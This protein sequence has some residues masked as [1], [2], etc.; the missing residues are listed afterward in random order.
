[1]KP[2]EAKRRQV[3]AI[4]S[5]LL[6]ASLFMGLA[7]NQNVSADG[8]EQKIIQNVKT[9][10]FGSDGKI[11]WTGKIEAFSSSSFLGATF[12]EAPVTSIPVKIVISSDAQLPLVGESKT[13]N[14]CATAEYVSEPSKSGVP[15]NRLAIT[16]LT[17]G[18]CNVLVTNPGN[19]T[20][21][22]ISKEI[23]I[24]FAKAKQYVNFTYNGANFIADTKSIMTEGGAQISVVG[25]YPEPDM[26]SGHLKVKDSLVSLTK[27][28]CSVALY[29]ELAAFGTVGYKVFAHKPGNCTLHY[30]SKATSQYLAVDEI[31]KFK[32]VTMKNHMNVF[33][34]NPRLWCDRIT[35]S[36]FELLDIPYKTSSG[37]SN[38]CPNG[39]LTEKTL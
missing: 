30:K 15:N 32:F 4:F 31:V 29:K 10:A 38:S 5:I 39:Y 8:I 17:E 27:P 2:S 18:L 19:E 26:T 37:K 22:P 20:V 33:T 12:Y 23:S 9:L 6:L 1:M 34:K 21:M 25:K 28:I 35:N 24:T 13:P 3:Q 7:S 16:P 11:D 36:I 14:I